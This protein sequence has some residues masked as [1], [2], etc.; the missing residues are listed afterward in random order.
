MASDPGFM[1]QLGLKISDL[2]GGGAG[3]TVVALIMQK[4]GIYNIVGSVIIG[5][6]TAGYLTAWVV[7]FTGT[8]DGGAP[9]VVGLCAT[10]ICAMILK[11]ITRWFPKQG[12]GQ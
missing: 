5:T 8:F 2:V 7:H 12:G 9:F 10:P 4:A 1:A 11:G 3:G 6:F